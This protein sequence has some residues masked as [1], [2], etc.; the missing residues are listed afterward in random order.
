[1]RRNVV[2]MSCNVTWCNAFNVFLRKTKDN[3]PKPLKA[4]F[5]LR[6]SLLLLCF[7]DCFPYG[8]GVFGLPRE[9]PLTFQQC[10]SMHLLREELVYTISPAILN[11]AAKWFG[12]PSQSFCSPASGATGCTCSQ[13]VAACQPFVPPRQPRW[14]H[15]RDLLCCYYDTWRRMDQIR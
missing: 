7:P 4:L 2:G 15:D 12:I 11:E 8:D 6:F 10:A 14:G 3:H 13:C 9:K 1:M 5:L